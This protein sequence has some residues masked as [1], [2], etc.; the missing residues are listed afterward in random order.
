MPDERSQLVGLQALRGLAA[1]L[2]VFVH[3]NGTA[4]SRGFNF[5]ALSHVV[6]GNIGVDIFFVIS[7]FIME[8]ITGGRFFV[9]GDR[10]RFL[11]RR[12]VRV[13]PLYWVLTSAVF[14]AS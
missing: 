9:A 13:L 11:V 4:I 6:I 3:Y 8:L 5:P 1:L 14:L 12:A 10:K 7:G 2:V